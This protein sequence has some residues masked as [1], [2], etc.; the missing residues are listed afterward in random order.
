MSKMTTYRSVANLS[1]NIKCESCRTFEGEDL[2]LYAEVVLG[3]LLLPEGQL[4]AGAGIPVKLPILD[5][6]HFLP[7]P[8]LGVPVPSYDEWH[9]QQCELVPHLTPA[10]ACVALKNKNN[11]KASAVGSKSF[12]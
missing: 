12:S 11:Y 10:T 5:T 4:Y 9:Q 2:P 3:T 7:E 6:S 8:L 1:G